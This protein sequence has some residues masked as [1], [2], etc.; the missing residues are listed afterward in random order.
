MRIHIRP[1]EEWSRSRISLNE[2][3]CGVW[4]ANSNG[5]LYG[6]K[7][8]NPVLVRIGLNI[9]KRHKGESNG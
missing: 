4:L 5:E 7:L 9:V 1:R 2:N 8:A 3:S 6:Q